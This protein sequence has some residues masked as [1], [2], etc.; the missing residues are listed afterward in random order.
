MTSIVSTATTIL[1][2][3]IEAIQFGYMAYLMWRSRNH[4]SNRHIQRA[5]S[6]MLGGLSASIVLFLLK[7]TMHHEVL[8]LKPVEKKLFNKAVNV[9]KPTWVGQEPAWRKIKPGE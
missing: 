1:W 6:A 3:L 9:P 4:V 7:R 5:R 2:I 8:K